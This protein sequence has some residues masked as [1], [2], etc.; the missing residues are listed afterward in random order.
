MMT[1]DL[2]REACLI[3]GDWR[4][5]SQWLEVDNPATGDVIGRVPSMEGDAVREAIG[6]AHKAQ[7]AWAART[8][9]DRALVMR[10]FFELILQHQE[11]LAHIL[12]EEQG[13]PLSEARSEITY[14]AGFV[15]WFSE[16]AKRIYG[17]VIPPHSA[18]KRN[19]VIK[20]PIGVVAAITPWNFPAAMITRKIAPALSA[21]CAVVLKPANQTPF[22][23]L[24]LG[25]L[26]QAAG[27]PDGVLNVI[28]GDS[29]AIGAE[30]TTNPIV[31]KISFTGSTAV[32]SKLMAQSAPTIKKLSLELGGN[33]PFI[34][35]DDADI[36][37]A[38]EGA[39]ASKFRNA[40]QTCVCANRIYAQAGIYDIF[41]ERLAK[42]AGALRVGPGMDESSQVGPLVDENALMKV[43]AHVADALDKGATLVTGGHRLN[44]RFY[45]PT[46]VRDVTRDMIVMREETFG[47]LAP[48]MR[49]NTDE[50]AIDLANDT[51]FGLAAY[52]YT[53]DI[54]RAW[55]V[56]EAIESGMV[57]VNT[58]LISTEVAPFGGVKSSGLGREGSKY[59]IE[60][61]LEVKYI[62]FGI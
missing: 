27:V 59:G 9:K 50:D 51:E 17:D 6:A 43:E 56:A 35:F 8:A 12:T 24:A 34:V 2:K 13:K 37:A 21:G 11:A 39:I 26:A 52:F 55:K 40:G 61:Y 30:F 60:D 57:G 19:V 36:N 42:A 48:V 44:G 20:Q 22:T 58:G 62:C 38:V 3:G 31:R 46:V 16:E 10:A 33:A 54:S 25:A 29:I 4:T 32:G 18:D 47:P 23:A 49:F 41:V 7:P 15:E 5:A 45:A 14:A 53:R 28:T 1:V